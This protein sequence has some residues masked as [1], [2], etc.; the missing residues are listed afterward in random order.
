MKIQLQRRGEWQK[1][2]L[3]RPAMVRVSGMAARF[4]LEW[5]E[6]GRG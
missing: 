1:I 2:K 3:E 4:G 6:S 5:K